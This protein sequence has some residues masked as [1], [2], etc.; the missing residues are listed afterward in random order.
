M[1]S[2]CLTR[3]ELLLSGIDFERFVFAYIVPCFILIGICGNII[4]LTVLLSPPMRK[5][6]IL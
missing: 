6:L 2:Y 5:R 3:N 4:N 1:N